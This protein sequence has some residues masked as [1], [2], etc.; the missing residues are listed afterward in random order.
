MIKKLL[1]A[2]FCL[3]GV[4]T[5]YSF[6]PQALKSNGRYSVY[7]GKINKEKTVKTQIPTRAEMPDSL[8]FTYADEVYS[9][10]TLGNN[11]PLGDTIYLA[12]KLTPDVANQFAGDE[13]TRLN[14]TTGIYTGGIGGDSNLV[15]NI[16]IFTMGEN[17]SQPTYIQD[18]ELGTSA[19]TEYSIKLDNPIKIEQDKSITVG[20]S[21]AV[22]N[23]SMYYIPVDGVPTNNDAGCIF[24]YRQK[25]STAAISWDTFAPSYGSICLGC[26]IKG[27]KFPEN[28]AVFAGLYGEVYAEPGKEFDYHF[29][30]QGKSIL[31][32]SVD[33]TVK[34]GDGEAVSNV[35]TLD[36]PIGYNEYAE[37]VVP[38]VCD[39]EWMSVPVTYTLAKV[40]NVDNIATPNE[41]TVKID[42]F[43]REKGYDRVNLI[44]EGTGTWCGW[45][46][47][48]IVMM[49]YVR[50]NYPDLFAGVAL[51]SDDRMAAPSTSVV[52]SKLFKGFP[53]AVINR[54]VDLANMS[55]DEI[56]QF[57]AIYGNA[58]AKMGFDKLDASVDMEGNITVNAT[59]G[60]GFDIDNSRDTYRLAFYL[61]QN[62]MGPYAQTNY[63][64]G[65]QAGEMEGWES[66][67]QSVQTI[68]N[69]VARYLSGGY[70]GLSNSIA[71]SLAA[72]ESCD[73][74]TSFTVKNVTAAEFELVAFIVDN[75]SGE[76]ANAKKIK[77]DNVYYTGIDDIASSADVVSKK[78]YNVNGVEVKEPSN[79]IYIVRS[80]LSDGTVKTGK[81]M[82][83]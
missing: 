66:K 38:A 60:T 24:G 52:I 41:V 22:P 28:Q 73:Y 2:A 55:I 53:S 74:T 83:K 62:D 46:P 29:Y 80:V 65:G 58:P 37:I 48:G 47:R 36:E 59:V 69:D 68:Y 16:R 75:N 25:N 71:S 43:P 18:A 54:S 32:E 70:Y 51:H 4:A 11:A 33:V 39:K 30:I 9:A 17:D 77:V 64:A 12:F 5:A 20:Y 23:T 45:C 14:V 10:L 78:F 6:G 57:V 61:V 81:T 42:C 35:I 82:V 76:I 31:T 34:V 15:K 27:D 50:E 19:Y 13:I 8:N 3:L 1:P 67:G 44:E 21:F 79:G 63:Y 56:E 49:E 26:T 72:G 40:N 7:P